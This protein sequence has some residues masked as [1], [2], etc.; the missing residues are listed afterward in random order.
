M[1]E[2][3]AHFR[4]CSSCHALDASW[5]LPRSGRGFVAN[6]FD[7]VPVGPNDERC[8]VVRV[9]ARAQAWR[10]IVPATGVECGAMESIDLLPA[11]GRKR[12]MKMRRLL[13]GLV[14]A[15]GDIALLRAKLDAVSRR[16][17]RNNS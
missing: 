17:L 5:D 4:A 16:P 9:V 8:I 14:Q 2:A 6:R 12:Q 3:A 11:P 10:P 7:V 1:G 15:Q 13:L